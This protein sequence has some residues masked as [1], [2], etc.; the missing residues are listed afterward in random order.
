MEISEIINVELQVNRE[1]VGDSVLIN[2]DPTCFFYADTKGDIF[3]KTHLY[4]DKRFEVY[5]SEGNHYLKLNEQTKEKFYAS[6]RYLVEPLVKDLN[7]FLSERKRET[8]K[9]IDY[10]PALQPAG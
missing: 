6:N 2:L 4:K 1:K 7:D 8:S 10:S 5:D 3:I 9:S